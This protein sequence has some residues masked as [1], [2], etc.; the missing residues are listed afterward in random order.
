ML[1]ARIIE[2]WTTRTTG[3]VAAMVLA[4]LTI[5]V[6]T[7][8]QM[9]DLAPWLLCGFFGMVAIVT[10]GILWAECSSAKWDRAILCAVIDAKCAELTR[11]ANQPEHKQS[12][13]R[14]RLLESAVVHARDAVVILKAC[15]DSQSGRAVMY[16]NDAFTRMT[17]YSS[18]EVL[19]RSLH[20][21]GG[22]KTDP[23]TLEQMR[24]ALNAGESL[25]VELLNYRKDGSEL[26]VE[27]SLVPV[28][29]RTGRCCSHWV[30]I[31]RDVG[32][33]KRAEQE[34]REREEQLRVVGDNLPGGVVYQVE[35]EHPGNFRYTY[36]SA[37]IER[38]TG[39]TVAEVLADSQSLHGLIHPED[40]ARFLED[41]QISWRDLTPL[42]CEFRQYTTSGELRWIHRRSMPEVVADG[43]R[44][45]NGVLVDVTE[46]RNLEDQLRQAQKME[47][48]GQLAGGIAHDF[49]NLLTGVLGNLNLV[50]LPPDDPNRSLI[51][52]AERAALRAAD[53][54]RKLL[55]FARKNQLL[56]MPVCVADFIGEVTDL[57]DRTLD[58]RI[59]IS[60]DL[61]ATPPVMADA[62]LLNQVLLN[63]CIN[64]RDA[65][66]QGG[67]LTIRTRTV[68]I[69]DR[70]TQIHPEARPG[71]YVRVT[72]EDTGVGM[73]PTVKARLFEPFFTTKP[74]GQGTGLGLAMVHGIVKQH[75][76]WIA[77]DSEPNV[78][79]RFHMYLPQ[80]THVASPKS[81]GVFS[82]RLLERTVLPSTDVTTPPPRATANQT[83]LLVDD[84]EMIR[85]I[86]R[87]VLEAAGFRVLEAEDGIAAIDVFHRE[88][89][90]IALVI[91]DLMMPRLSGQDAFQT[92]ITID[93]TARILLSSGYSADDISDVIGAYGRLSKPYRPNDLLSAV[94]AALACEELVGSG[95]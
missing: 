21:L 44:R 88:Y 35:V 54:T 92:L 26:W 37:G 16:V 43:R 17:G 87:N 77:C 59:H 91:L 25:Q 53:L 55:G 6:T 79:T 14:L 85:A 36:I 27:L 29:D 33:R 56:V 62:T 45:W 78:G 82:R 57:L 48:V 63:L 41:C 65:M 86:G 31:Q 49:N 76:G 11:L 7:F 4:L 5:L 93:P 23:R 70:D 8:V 58:P 66:P 18:A 9:P 67:K 42:N 19:G 46:R 38:I 50:V 1:I 3:V 61:A 94:K 10:L 40:L 12:E 32:E 39:V 75:N 81:S 24:K 80:A 22:P 68:E 20:L 95:E 64:A 2:E 89:A 30:M 72:V 60:T 73:T 69:D 34:L 15:V 74:L 83:V 47:T 84:E 28:P 13:E 90:T 52:T 51:H 71:S